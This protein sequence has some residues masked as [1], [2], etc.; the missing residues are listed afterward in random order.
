MSWLNRAQA[1]RRRWPFL[2]ALALLLVLVAGTFLYLRL[3]QTPPAYRTIS[4]AEDPAAWTFSLSD[5]TPAQPDEAGVFHLPA[6]ETIL[7]CVTTLPQDL[8]DAAFLGV[9]AQDMDAALLLNGAPVAQLC[10]SGGEGGPA[11]LFP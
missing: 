6:G 9:S 1:L 10:G 4:P 8:T 7:C 11:S 2:L 3:A 5:G